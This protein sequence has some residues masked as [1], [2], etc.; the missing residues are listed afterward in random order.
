MRNNK[1]SITLW[2]GLILLVLLFVWSAINPEDLHTWFLEVI[3]VLVAVPVLVFTYRRFRFSDFA[4]IMIFI[5]LYILIVGGHYTYAKVPLFD[6]IREIFELERNNYD[7]VAHFIQGTTPAIIARE[8]F[9]RMNVIK[10]RG[11]LFFIVSSVTLAIS[12]AYELVEMAVSMAEGGEAD[13]F[14]GTQ[15]YVW[16]TQTDMLLALLG[17]MLVQVVFGKLHNRSIKKQE[18]TRK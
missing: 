11:W 17:A 9:I 7:K 5:Q 3:P 2:A 13:A 1:L 18:I 15:G 8:I 16:D 14:L 4:Y 12:A 10:G 6:W